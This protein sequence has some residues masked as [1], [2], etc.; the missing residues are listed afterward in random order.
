MAS[1][2]TPVLAIRPPNRDSCWSSAWEGGLDSAQSESSVPTPSRQ[3]ART[4]LPKAEPAPTPS[5]MGM[6]RA[7][8]IAIRRATRSTRL[9][10]DWMMMGLTEGVSE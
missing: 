6:V 7:I 5:A 1:W 8:S 10:R 2:G 9:R 3:A 4:S